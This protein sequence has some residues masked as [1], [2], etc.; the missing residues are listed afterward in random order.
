MLRVRM[1]EED[2]QLLEQAAKLQ[3][4]QLSSW[5][6]SEMVK[7]ARKLLDRHAKQGE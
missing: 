1:S 6:R 4:L 7:L 3:S 5:V 2:H